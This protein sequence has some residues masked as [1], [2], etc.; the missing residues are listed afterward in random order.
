MNHLPV[1]FVF[2]SK[3][4]IAVKSIWKPTLLYAAAHFAVDFGCAFAVFS[5]CTGGGP[6]F[7][8]YNFCAFA[9]QMP[10]G[11]LADRVGRNGWFAALGCLLTAALCCVPSFGLTGAAILGVGNGLFHVGGGLDVLNGSSRRA[12]PLGVFVSPGALGLFCG[13]LLG[14]M[15]AEPLPVA[16]LLLLMAALILVFCRPSALPENAPLALPRRSILPMAAALF[17]VVVLRSYGGMAADFSWKTGL[18]SWAAV[19]AVVLGKTAGGFAAD[20]IGAKK[21]AGVSLVLAAALFC[22]GQNAFAGTAAL[23]L[24]N[25]TMPI[26][27]WALARAMPG[28]KGFSF[29]LLT[30]ALFLGFLPIYLGAGTAGGYALAGIS[31]LS[32]VLLGAAIRT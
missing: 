9:L 4:G 12:G 16:G 27:L 5:A 18:W 22:F 19:L 21:A 29:G 30:F 3:G 14:H 25:M 28:C 1:F 17:L 15:G 24:F 11:L 26:T 7:L 20:R 10:L 32:A 8:L 2:I 31:L 13:T 23:F 6:G